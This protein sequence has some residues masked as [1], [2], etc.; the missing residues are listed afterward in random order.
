MAKIFKTNEQEKALKDIVDSLKIIGSINTIMEDEDIKDLKIRLTG[1]V[2][3]GAV[4][5]LI[6]MPFSIISSQIKD[7]RKRLIKEVLDKSK[8]YSIRLEEDEKE[9]LG[10]KTKKNE[11]EKTAV[12][13]QTTPTDA[14]Q[15]STNDNGNKSDSHQSNGYF[16]R[17]HNY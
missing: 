15:P 17:P 8:T 10:I 3:A 11:E 14:I 13:E 16:Q 7:Y 5:E 6:P 4:N 1:T 12:N 9:I 2:A